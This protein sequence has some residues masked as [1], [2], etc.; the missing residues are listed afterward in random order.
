MN[1]SSATTVSEPSSAPVVAAF[2]AFVSSR[3]GAQSSTRNRTPSGPNR[4]NNG[5]AT[6]PAF[7]APNSAA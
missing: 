5:T 1:A 4:V 7:I 2:S 3:L 6:A